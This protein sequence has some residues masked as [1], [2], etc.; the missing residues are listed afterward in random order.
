[1]GFLISA[2]VSGGTTQ[3]KVDNYATRNENFI[4]ALAAPLHHRL[5]G[6]DAAAGPDLGRGLSR[7]R[8]VQHAPCLRHRRCQSLL[9]AL[10]FMHLKS[11][12]ALNRI[13]AIGALVWL[14]ILFAFLLSD[15]FT[16][17]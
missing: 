17:F 4:F 13:F 15:Y 1:M 8:R 11:G 14:L 2:V 16:R 5:S 12:K 3:L 10:F 7:F 6:F 9:I